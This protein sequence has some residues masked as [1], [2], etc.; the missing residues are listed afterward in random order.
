MQALLRPRDQE[1]QLQFGD[2]N[3]LA[4]R[5]A[6]GAETTPLDVA[7]VTPAALAT[8]PPPWTERVERSCSIAAADC[9]ADA[10]AGRS[11]RHACRHRLAAARSASARDRRPRPR[12]G[13]AEPLSTR[14]QS[15]R[16][17]IGSK[18]PA[19]SNRTLRV[20]LASSVLPVVPQVSI[21]IC[22]AISLTLPM[23]QCNFPCLFIRKGTCCDACG[24][25]WRR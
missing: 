20:I 2:L 6:R 3:G 13:D 8:G 16:R 25:A 9:D 7:G 24:C 21:M 19:C 17:A 23:M 22:G 5:E 1:E 10:G 4:D 15:P 12:R 18:I 11:G 14:L